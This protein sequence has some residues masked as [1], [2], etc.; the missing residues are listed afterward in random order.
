[1]NN[2][3]QTGDKVMNTRNQTEYICENA[4]KCFSPDC[5]HKVKHELTEDCFGSWCGRFKEYLNCIR[6]KD[7]IK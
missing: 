7:L 3:N 2:T 5:P 4:Y 6:V 1:M